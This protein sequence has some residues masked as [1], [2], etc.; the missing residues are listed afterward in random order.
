MVPRAPRGR[1]G[2]PPPLSCAPSTWAAGWSWALMHAADAQFPVHSGKHQLCKLPGEGGCVLR[3]LGEPCCEA[4][5]WARKAEA[6]TERGGQKHRGRGLPVEPARKDA[7]TKRGCASPQAPADTGMARRPWSAQGL[8]GRPLQ[9]PAP[10]ELS[11]AASEL[12]GRAKSPLPASWSQQASCPGEGAQGSLAGGLHPGSSAREGGSAQAVRSRA[13]NEQGRLPSQVFT[14]QAGQGAA[15]RSTPTRAVERTPQ[16]LGRS[17]TASATRLLDH[18]AGSSPHPTLLGSCPS[19]F[20][21]LVGHLSR[22][23]TE[24][25]AVSLC[26]Y[27]FRESRSD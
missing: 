26:Q 12:A 18:G 8:R 21:S 13:E 10:A 17:D 11:R 20:L 19:V 1:C 22:V 24:Y 4:V 14:A 27:R 9:A 2:C 25:S 5:P 6:P 3:E 7:T 15:Q 23:T 16:P